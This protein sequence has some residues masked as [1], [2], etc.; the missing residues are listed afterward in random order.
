MYRLLIVDDEPVIADGLF[1]FFQEIHDIE[2]D[3]YKAYSGKEALEIL[4][5]TKVDIVLTD[6]CMPGIDGL[7]IQKY[8]LEKWPRCKVIFLTG[9]SDFAYAQSAIRNEGADYILKT[10]GDDFI[11]KAVKKA[12]RKID[13]QVKNEQLI[14]KAKLNMEMALPLLQNK[15]ILDILKGL[16]YDKDQ[17]KEQFN[18]FKLNLDVDENVMLMLG[19]IDVWPDNINSKDSIQIIYGVQNTAHEYLAEFVNSVS[20]ILDNNRIVWL[21]QPKFQCTCLSKRELWDNAIFYIQGNIDTIQEYCKKIFNV[22]I[23]LIVAS[24]DVHWCEVARKFDSLEM[25]LNRVYGVKNSVLLIDN[26]FML[27]M[28]D[29]NS[30]GID[31]ENKLRYQIKRIG[32]LRDYLEVGE[33]SKFFSLYSSIMKIV[34][35]SNFISNNTAEEIYYSISIIF[36]SYINKCN[37][38]SKIEKYIDLRKLTNMNQHKSW[39]DIERY[40]YELAEC[41]FRIKKEDYLEYN[42]KIVNCINMHIKNNLGGDLSLANLASQLHYNPSYLS[43]LYK[44]TMGQGSLN[45]YHSRN[46]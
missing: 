37:L 1:D 12:I 18:N 15:C 9:F 35:D 28:Q 43:R 44:E 45:I 13:E 19:R 17:L 20:I 42:N 6:I 31:D 27:D 39:N 3:V 36:L 14:E 46:F 11:L 29:V 40:F 7:K 26:A 23:S 16:E 38:S 32:L 8:I 10:E 41:I 21:M 30:N 33:E 24:E 22:S 5:K 34:K 4:N 2:L 25:A